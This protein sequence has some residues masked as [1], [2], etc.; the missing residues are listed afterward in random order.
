MV[1]EQSSSKEQRLRYQ[2]D[3]ISSA[4]LLCDFGWGCEFTDTTFDRPTV[5]F[6]RYHQ[7]SKAVLLSYTPTSN[8]LDFQFL[9]TLTSILVS[10]FYPLYL[11]LSVSSLRNLL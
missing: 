10:L 5:S 3:I 2:I 6:S 8:V 7:F 11:A 4:S 1:E 9:H